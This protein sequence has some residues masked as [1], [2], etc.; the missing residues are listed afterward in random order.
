MP[1]N[2]SDKVEE[3]KKEID[4]WVEEFSKS[5]KRFDRF[6]VHEGEQLS[7]GFL[8]YKDD[9]GQTTVLISMHG[10]KPTN[11]LSFPAN[12]LEDVKQIT[13]M[14]EKYEELFKYIEKYEEN[15]KSVRKKKNLLE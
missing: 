14:L 12:A 13:K 2:K 5:N 3:L 1:S 10:Q 9:K 8:A 6:D 15:V 4:N 11:S 7:L